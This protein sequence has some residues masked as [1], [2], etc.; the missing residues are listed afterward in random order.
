MC[1]PMDLPCSRDTFESVAAVE[2]GASTQPADVGKRDLDSCRSFLFVFCFFVL[3]PLLQTADSKVSDSDQVLQMCNERLCV[4]EVL[5]SP[6]DVSGLA[7]MG[8]VEAI[9]A[10]TQACPLW[11][12]PLMYDNILLVGGNAKLPNFQTRIERELRPLVNAEFKINVR[13]GKESVPARIHT[14]NDRQAR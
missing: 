10:A 7:Q 5:F 12:Q 9:V 8:L 13:M 14:H 11:M 3:V 1:C 2:S 4:P 6:S